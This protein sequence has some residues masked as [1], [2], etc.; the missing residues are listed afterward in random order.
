MNSNE[1]KPS[2]VISNESSLLSDQC[3]MDSHQ[4]YQKIIRFL[5]AKELNEEDKIAERNWIK[6]QSA[7]YYVIAI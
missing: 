3:E 6:I 7:N 4:Y 1:N 2:K 5:Q